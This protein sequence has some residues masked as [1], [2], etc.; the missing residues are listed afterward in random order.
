MSKRRKK[1]CKSKVKFDTLDDALVR[2]EQ[3]KLRVYR[4]PYCH[5]Y[6]LTK[7][8]KGTVASG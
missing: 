8:F 3:V 4:C 6:H 7:T 2:A 1:V 5:R